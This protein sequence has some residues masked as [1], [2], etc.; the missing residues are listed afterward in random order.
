MPESTE[1]IPNSAVDDQISRE[2]PTPDQSSSTT[3]PEKLEA[4]ENNVQAGVRAVEAAASAWST[5][6]LVAAY[7]M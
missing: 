2:G 3:D 5:K 7:V 6:H 1:K 4:T